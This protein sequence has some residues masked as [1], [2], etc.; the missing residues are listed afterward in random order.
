MTNTVK[1]VW[2]RVQEK[3]A[4]ELSDAESHHLALAVLTIILPGESDIVIVQ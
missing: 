4:D 1:A 3:P 2:W